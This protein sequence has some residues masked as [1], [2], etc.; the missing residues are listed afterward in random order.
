[1]KE[2]TRLFAQLTTLLVYMPSPIESRCSYCRHA[3]LPC[4]GEDTGILRQDIHLFITLI[5]DLTSDPELCSD[6]IALKHA[7]CL[8]NPRSIKEL[9][10]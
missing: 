1:M 2:E 4:E 8:R 10:Q 6:V 9:T 3:V 7:H 5:A